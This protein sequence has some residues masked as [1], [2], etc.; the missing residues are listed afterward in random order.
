MRSNVEDE[1]MVDS[2]FG[3][4]VVDVRSC[5]KRFCKNLESNIGSWVR[6]FKVGGSRH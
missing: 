5:K 4:R 6:S 1:A 3:V 2:L